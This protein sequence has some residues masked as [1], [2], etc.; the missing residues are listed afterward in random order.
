ML[1]TFWPLKEPLHTY[2]HTHTHAFQANFDEFTRFLPNFC[3][4]WVVILIFNLFKWLLLIVMNGA[5]WL[6]S[7]IDMSGLW[8]HQL[9]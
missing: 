1:K 4:K 7:P 6:T 8:L 9:S 5:P 2:T 3:T